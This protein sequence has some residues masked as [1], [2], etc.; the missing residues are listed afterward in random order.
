MRTLVTINREAVRR[1]VASVYDRSNKEI[2]AVVKNNAYN[3]GMREMVETLM[4]AGVR[5]FA[6]AEMYEAIEIKT[7]FPDSYC[8]AMNPVDTFDDARK[9]GIALGIASSEWVERHADELSGIELHLK[10]NV[11]M[12]RFGISSLEEAEAVL[13]LSVKH[14]L[15]LTGLYTHFPLAD[16]PE[17][18]HDSQ[19]DAFV[20]IADALRA[21]HVFDYIHS[22]NSATLV[23]RDPRLAF[24]NYV[25]PGI[26]LFGYS[27]IEA[28]DWLVPSLRMTTEVV[29]IRDVAPG[30]H[31]GYG[32]SFTTETATRVAMLP[33]G[34]GDG[35]VRARKALPVIINGKTY[36]II[37][38]LFMSHTFVAVDDDVAVG[39]EVVL[40]GDGIEI[41]DITRTGAA[42]NSEQMCARSWRLAHRYI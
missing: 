37:S 17:A 29:M 34:Y 10:V 9:Y 27:P 13:A 28:M 24:C 18:D 2:F 5:H 15:K 36:P 1:N 38:K 39:D 12:N 22:E 30:K 6:V 35:V 41:D 16:E 33:V 20:T 4:D 23:K 42:N 11:G 14:D 26:F 31:V 40:Y 21:R 32:T 19:V 3:L 7:N 8:L 25:R